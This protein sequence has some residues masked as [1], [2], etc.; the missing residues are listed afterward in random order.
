MGAS[1]R[2]SVDLVSTRAG[3]FSA[4]C[5]LSAVL[6]LSRDSVENHEA[7]KT[8]DERVLAKAVGSSSKPFG[9]K[10]VPDPASPMGGVERLTPLSSDLMF[11]IVFLCT[12]PGHNSKA[13]R[14]RQFTFLSANVISAVVPFQNSTKATD[15][16]KTASS[17]QVILSRHQRGAEH[18]RY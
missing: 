17:S 10:V 16:Y 5:H 2:V 15:D 7:V 3:Y 1:E 9:L 18:W 12:D 14:S 11:R 13:T 8:Q 6:S 4:L